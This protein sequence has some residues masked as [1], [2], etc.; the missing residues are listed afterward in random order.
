LNVALAPIPPDEKA[1]L[2]A[3]FDV[4]QAE[5]A[6]LI[7]P[8]HD[9]SAPAPYPWFDAY[10]TEPD[11]I[12]LWILADSDRAGFALLNRHSPSGLG[13]DR[14]VA[15]FCIFERYRRSGLG[16]A[17]ART[18]FAGWPGLWELEVR[19]ANAPGLAFWR[20]VVEAACPAEHM[21]I[22]SPQALIHRF[23]AA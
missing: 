15:E 2:R 1:A 17:A 3:V 6:A 22:D 23:R 7:E 12:P 14:A 11:R 18:I 9:P 5:H 19:K 10:W 13:C 8:G 4:Y 16:Q 20:S 21:V